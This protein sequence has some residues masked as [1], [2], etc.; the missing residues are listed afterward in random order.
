MLNVILREDLKEYLAKHHR[1]DISVSLVHNDYSTC[2]LYT[3]QPR[4]NF[5]PTRDERNYDSYLID[6]VRVFVEKEIEAI[7]NTIEFV[8]ETFLGVHRCHVRG[9]KLDSELRI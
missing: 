1:N 9:V 3:T 6:G 7:D 4:I 5:R 2:I 8:E